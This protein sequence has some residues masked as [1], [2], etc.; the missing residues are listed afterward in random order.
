[1][2]KASRKCRCRAVMFEYCDMIRR[3]G[4]L[5]EEP[6]DVYILNNTATSQRAAAVSSGEPSWPVLYNV[7]EDGPAPV[8]DGRSDCCARCTCTPTNN[9]GYA[10]WVGQHLLPRKVVTLV[11]ENQGN[12]SHLQP[13]ATS[14]HCATQ[15]PPTHAGTT[16]Q[17]QYR[18]LSIISDCFIRFKFATGPPAPSGES[19]PAPQSSSNRN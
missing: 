16:Q 8:R 19:G 17:C 7:P 14:M 3:S 9:G 15:R 1:M 6:D 2:L 18:S 5:S 10:R 12:I 11:S 4:P 13:L